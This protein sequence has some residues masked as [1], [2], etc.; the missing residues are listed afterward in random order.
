MNYMQL[1]SLLILFMFSIFDV[2]NQYTKEKDGE[3]KNSFSQYA[4]DK[5][6]L[7]YKHL[8]GK[9]VN[10]NGETHEL[11]MN[12]HCRQNDYYGYL[13]YHEQGKPIYFTGKKDENG[14]IVLTELAGD[15]KSG[16][17]TGTFQN[18]TTFAGT[19]SDSEKKNKATFELVQDYS[20]SVIFT[21][22]YREKEYHLNSN[23][24]Y[25]RCKIDITYHHPIEYTAGRTIPIIRTKVMDFFF[26]KNLVVNQP[27]RSLDN[28]VSN[29]IKEYKEF[30]KDFDPNS[31]MNYTYNWEQSSNMGILFNDDNI[32]T[33][34][35]GFYQYSGG[36]HG[37]FGTDFYSIN[38]Q[39]GAKIELNDVFVPDFRRI[40]TP[41]IIDALKNYHQVETDK[42]LNEILFDLNDIEVSENFYICK[43]GIGFYYNVYE[44]APYAAG[45]SEAF[46]PFE[47]IKG[48]LRSNSPV[49]HF[50]EK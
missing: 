39:T 11:S 23:P 34:Y 44:I 4:N 21:S 22:F 9:I 18:K 28:Y 36:A 40:V 26:G 49:S 6:E 14:N 12:L 13:Y 37:I 17:F 47:K 50:I 48:V 43:G 42:E 3:T 25:P 7:Y 5:P 29:Y 2:E 30:E 45:T 38:L 19:K 35:T 10:K 20:G 24:D 1:F 16:Y 32:L 46:I 41:L 31:E 15:L 8:T 33:I 27:N